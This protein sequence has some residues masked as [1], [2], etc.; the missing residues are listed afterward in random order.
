MAT[1]FEL[2]DG[3][4]T[5][6]LLDGTDY[7]LTGVS[8]GGA[9]ERQETFAG[10][11]LRRIKFLPHRV[12]ATLNILGSSTADLRGAIRS[13]T[14]MLRKAEGRQVLDQGTKIVLKYQLGSTDADDISQRVLSGSLIMPDSVIDQVIVDQNVTVNARLSLLL[15]PLGRLADETPS[16]AILENEQEGANLNYVDLTSIEGTSGGRLELKVHDDNN[17]NGNAWNGNKKMWIAKRSGERRTDT[18]FL[19]TPD[20]VATGGVQPS[21]STD[22]WKAQ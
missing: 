14:E 9:D 3:S 8:F 11:E 4:T 21:A 1:T 16:T 15:E 22:I 13:L 17:G 5:L 12:E 6:N 7:S 19:Q 2:Y 18:L 20:S 10:T